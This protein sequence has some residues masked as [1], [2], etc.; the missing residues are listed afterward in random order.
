MELFLGCAFELLPGISGKSELTSG[1]VIH[2][3]L[4]KH[5]HEACPCDYVQLELLRTLVMIF[6]LTLRI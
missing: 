6:L 2:K 5:R 3:P 4:W 1:A